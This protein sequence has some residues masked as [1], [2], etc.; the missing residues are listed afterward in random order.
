MGV[1]K[2]NFKYKVLN[3]TDER[4]IADTAECL[5]ETFTGIKIGDQLI[6]EPMSHACKLSKDGLIP[7]VTEYLKHAASQG[8]C[9]IA[10]E[11]NSGKVIGAMLCEDFNPQEEPSIFEGDIE[12]INKIGEFLSELNE[13]FV[14]TVETKTGKRIEK[15]EYVHGV[16]VGVRAEKNK[17][18]IAGDMLKI[19]TEQAKE[20]NYKGI[21]VEATNFKSQKFNELFGF[22]TAKDLENKP[23]TKRYSTN[24][25]FRQIPEDIALECKLMIKPL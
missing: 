5:S 13:N 11:N 22:Y 18:Y 9:I 15:N 8:L 12:N 1:K 19:L 3:D 23:I 10:E 24:E 17:K 20:K 16:M 4:L 7:Y 2:F 6:R 21:I 25:T 14:K